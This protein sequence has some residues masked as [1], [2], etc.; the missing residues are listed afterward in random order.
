V[1]VDVIAG[2]EC[3]QER[4][5]IIGRN[6]DLPGQGVTGAGAVLLHR[7]PSLK[8]SRGKTGGREL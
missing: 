3:A 1:A 7:I 8:K 5:G 4:A 6:I 2:N